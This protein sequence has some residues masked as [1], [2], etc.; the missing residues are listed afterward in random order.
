M[1]KLWNNGGSAKFCKEAMYTFLKALWAQGT[2]FKGLLEQLHYLPFSK[3]NDQ[4]LFTLQLHL[5][6]PLKDRT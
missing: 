6:G 5:R 1:A 3:H 2:N 4:T